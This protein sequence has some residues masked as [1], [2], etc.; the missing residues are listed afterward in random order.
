[1]EEF[2]ALLTPRKCR[3]YAHNGG[4]FDWHYIV[5]HLEP[6][7]DLMVIAGRLAK[8]RIGE[9]EFRDS[10]NI[11]PMPLKAGGNKF[12]IDYSILEKENRDVPANR[13]NIRE[14][15]RTDCLYLAQMLETFFEEFGHHLTISG[16][17]MD[18]W[19]KISGIDKPDSGSAFYEHFAPYYFGGRV[20]VFHAGEFKGPFRIIDRNSAYPH[21]MLS[22]HPWG[23]IVNES[24]SLPKARGALERSFITLDANST[25]A[26]PFR[27]DT[28]SLTFPADRLPR[29]FRVTGWEY[30]AALETGTLERPRVLSVSTVAESI[31]FNSYMDHFYKMK[32]TAK[33]QGDA[34]RYEFSKRFLCSL[35]GKFGSNPEE[36]REYK[37]V[38]P[39][40]IDVACEADGY[41]FNAELGPWALLSRPLHENRQRFYNVATAAS[42]T[43]FV[44]AGMWRS[45]RGVQVPLY[46]DTD[47]I[48]CVGTGQLE[49]D[50]EKLGAWK[51]EANCTYGAFAGRKL[52]ACQTEAGTWKTASKGV[53]LTAEQIVRIAQGETIE[54]EPEFPTYSV[55]QGIH[56]QTRKIRRTA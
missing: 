28:G 31:E 56:F 47:S 39:R 8:F 35:Y 19:S 36:Y 20:E 40:F 29:T 27:D 37:V 25:G 7:S 26:F 23:L 18:A 12:E 50:A 15:L 49:L 45:L 52:Y 5:P 3:V 4:K 21:A 53:R 41:L 22:L 17:S 1:M 38:E 13:E 2:L 54:H 33:Q 42:I 6:F 30:L 9:A 32:T 10:F 43:G 51:V 14:R 16:A 55:K 34:A 46:C 44:R 24:T 48:A 11:M